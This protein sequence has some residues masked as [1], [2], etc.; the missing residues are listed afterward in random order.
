MAE[1]NYKKIRRI[2]K[3]SLNRMYYIGGSIVLISLIFK[4]TN[5]RGSDVM[6][7]IGLLTEALIFF[8]GAFDI[9]DTGYKDSRNTLPQPPKQGFLSDCDIDINQYYT[10]INSDI[11]KIFFK[12]QNAEMIKKIGNIM[13]EDIFNNNDNST[14]NSLIDDFKKH[15]FK[16]KRTYKIKKHKKKDISVSVSTPGKRGR[17]K[18]NQ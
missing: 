13:S 18:K 5:T 6:M 12:I 8:L 16:K 9:D 7:I 2:I 10:E 15:V 1:W 11:K 17:K 14:E 4:F 3:T